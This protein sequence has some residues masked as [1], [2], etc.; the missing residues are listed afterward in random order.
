MKKYSSLR[1]FNI[2]QHAMINRLP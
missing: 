2:Y 1:V